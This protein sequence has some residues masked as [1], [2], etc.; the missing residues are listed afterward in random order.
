M[1]GRPSK[2]RALDAW[3]NGQRVGR[4]CVSASAVHSFQYDVAWPR[5]PHARPLSLSLPLSQTAQALHRGARVHGW[6]DHLLPSGA[7]ARQRLQAWHGA[8]STDA[9]DLLSIVGRDCVGALHLV[10]SDGHPGDPARIEAEPLTERELVR[11]VDACAGDPATALGPAA[12]PP[13]AALPGAQAQLALL[14]HGHRWCR[15]RGATPSTHVVKLPLGAAAGGAPAISTSLENEWLCARLL[16]AFG[17]AV[18][19][20][21]IDTVGPHKVL[22]IERVDRRWLSEGWCA[23]LPMEDFCQ[24]TGTLPRDARA[25]PTLARMLDVLRASDEAAQDRERLLAALVVL[26]MLA[27]P[28]ASAQRFALRWRPGSRFV[29]AP[30]PGVMSAWPVLGRAPSASS[31]KRLPWA[32]SPARSALTHHQATPAQWRDAARRQA[33]GASFGT[34]LDGLAAWTDRAIDSVSAQ[35]PAGFPHAVSDAIFDGLRRGARAF[36][37]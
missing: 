6:F 4:W 12:V 36:A 33:L 34:V 1:A 27:V 16:H 28:D 26:W 13:P 22:C 24:A 32:L 25:Q 10:S 14:W 35:L 9:F 11:L 23:R 8:A 5:S 2:A 37:A 29:L 18:A 3:M 19:P 30:L 7:L 31:L 21:R 17:F 15:P 20:S